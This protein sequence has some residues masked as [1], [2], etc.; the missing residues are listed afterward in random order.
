MMDD[1][2]HHINDTMRQVFGDGNIYPHT[3]EETDDG[4]RIHQL[5]EPRLDYE[6]PHITRAKISRAPAPR[7]LPRFREVMER[8][9]PPPAAA[10]PAVAAA[11]TWLYAATH[12]PSEATKDVLLN[13]A[14]EVVRGL[15]GDD[16]ATRA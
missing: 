13:K 12:Q 1:Y 16:D 14:T 6:Q 3:V 11:R 10:P 4:I 15:L 7:V 2:S 9:D 5:R 8:P